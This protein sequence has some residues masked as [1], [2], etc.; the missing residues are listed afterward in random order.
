M[1]MV[2]VALVARE[3]FNVY[4]SSVLQRDYVNGQC[5]PVID[6]YTV[7][8]GNINETMFRFHF[9][10]TSFCGSCWIVSKIDGEIERKIK[11]NCLY[12]DNKDFQDFQIGLVEIGLTF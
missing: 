8:E 2:I 12:K 10:H 4:A 5:I 9:L 3:I 1:L 11:I 6:K 7:H